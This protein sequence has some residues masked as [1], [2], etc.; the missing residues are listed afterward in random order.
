M[1]GSQTSWRN[2]EHLKTGLEM[3][4][5][6]DQC[7]DGWGAVMEIVKRV[8]MQMVCYSVVVWLDFP[9]LGGLLYQL[10]R[11]ARWAVCWFWG[12]ACRWFKAECLELDSFKV[13][14][15]QFFFLSWGTLIHRIM[16]RQS[17]IDRIYFR[18]LLGTRDAFNSS[19]LTLSASLK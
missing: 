19:V 15:R 12:G 7:I 17:D 5:C 14:I 16:Y 2:P 3:K 8:Y 18:T 9:H 11:L 1:L 4:W 6:M 10:T 13:Q